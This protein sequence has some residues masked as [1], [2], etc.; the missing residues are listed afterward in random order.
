MTQLLADGVQAVRI[1][2]D[3]EA[4]QPAATR[5]QPEPSPLGTLQGGDDADLPAN[6]PLI[7]LEMQKAEGRA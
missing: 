5:R 2:L 4:D 7:E 3:P 6:S 1:L